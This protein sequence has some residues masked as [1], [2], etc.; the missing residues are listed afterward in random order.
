MRPLRTVALLAIATLLAIPAATAHAED[1]DTGAVRDQ[2]RGPAPGSGRTIPAGR[3]RVS[4]IAERSGSCR[5]SVLESTGFDIPDYANAPWHTL[6]IPVGGTV[7]DITYTVNITH[8]ND[9]DLT[10]YAGKDDSG[11]VLTLSARNGGSGD[12]YQTTHFNDASATSVTAGTA[13]FNGWYRPQQALSVLNGSPANDRYWFTVGDAVTGNTGRVSSWGI[14]VTV[15][16]CDTDVDGVPDS[17]DRCDTIAAPSAS[18][19]P[20]A[21][22]QTQLANRKGAF[23]GHVDSPVTACEQGVRVTLRKVRPG[24]DLIIARTLTNGLGNFTTSY[25]T[26]AHGRFYAVLPRQVIP[27]V[28]ECRRAI[29]PALSR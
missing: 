10:L 20:V 3:V 4:P 22:R 2:V 6:W 27:D 17:T 1:G 29:S 7:A 12:N 28:A 15:D 11:S 18:G 25:P 26:S 19:C 5:V 13:P 21:A 16:N 8:P 9:A 14:T 23:R 24:N